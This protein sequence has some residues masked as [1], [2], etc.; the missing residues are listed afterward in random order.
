MDGEKIRASPRGGTGDGG[1]AATRVDVDALERAALVAGGWTARVDGARREVGGTVTRAK[2]PLAMAVRGLTYEVRARDDATKMVRLLDDVSAAFP[3]GRVCALMGP[4]GAGKTTLLDVMSGRKTRG[5]LTGQIVVGAEPATKAALK[6]CAAYV[7][8]F[9]TLLPSLTV[10]ETLMYQAELKRGAGESDMREREAIVEK[11]I[12][13]LRLSS[14]VDVIVGSALSRGIS[15]GQ[16]KRVNIGIS[17]VTR[18]RVLF[19]DEPTSGLDSQTSYE[20]M[21]VI[22]KF[23]DIDGVTVIATIHSPSSEAFR[24]FDRLLMLKSGKVTYAGPLFGEEGAEAYFYTLG[25]YFDPNDNFADFLI[26]T[27]ASNETDFAREF[28][29]SF[30]HKR[31]RDEVRKYIR[32]VI[33]RKDA[34]KTRSQLLA[35]APKRPGFLSAVWTLLKYR[36]TRNYRDVQ[37]LGARCGGHLIFAAVLATMYYDEGKTMTL[38][39]QINVSSMLFMNN[40][41]PAL[42]AGAYLPSILMERPLLYRELDDGCYPLLAYVAYKVIEEATA[43]FFVSLLATSIVYTTVGLR[44][45]FLVDWL[46]YFGVQQ[47]GAG[48]AYVCAAIARDVDAANAI[49]PIYNVLQILF[50]GLLLHND[51]VP[52]GWSW[53]PPTL[54]V[55]YGWQAQV[56]NHFKRSEPPAFLS[57]DGSLVGVIDYYGIQGTARANLAFIYALWFAWLFLA[58]IA[59]AAVRHQN[60]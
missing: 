43:A 22:R 39:S 34:G 1:D 15:G 31:N 44:G 14:C 49:L 5:C 4:S 13:D 53:W 30:H 60:R 35:D 59:T 51:D 16:A 46:A 17:L 21:R 56:V 42:A 6:T 2:A 57:D 47:C 45:N 23:C 24:Q 48:V 33:A 28:K 55:R 18:P 9:D 10:R 54:F 8:Q 3:P 41:L 26:S 36:T 40:V 37:F 12:D 11:L 19:L 58:A 20:L 52:K 25:Y 32:E 27:A 7:E 50:S 38:E 29:A